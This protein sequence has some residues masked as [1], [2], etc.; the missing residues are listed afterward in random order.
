MIAQYPAR[1]DTDHLRWGVDRHRK[2]IPT[3]STG[4]GTTMSG[5]GG[6]APHQPGL[7]Y[8]ENRWKLEL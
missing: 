1:R 2:E 7:K 8:R 6:S 5:S 3:L 4:M